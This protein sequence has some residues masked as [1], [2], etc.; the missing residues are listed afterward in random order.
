MKLSEILLKIF[1]FTLSQIWFIRVRK[2]YLAI[3]LYFILR[4]HIF[5]SAIVLYF[6]LRTHIFLS[7]LIEFNCASSCFNVFYKLEFC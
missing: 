1:R 2:K 3:V 4:T 7:S 6:I 5:V